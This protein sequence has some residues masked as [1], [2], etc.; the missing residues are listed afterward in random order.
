MA[1][2]LARLICCNRQR[3]GCKDVEI[4]LESKSA[5]MD[6]E[7]LVV[8]WHLLA[9][10]Y[11]VTAPLGLLSDYGHYGFNFLNTVFMKYCIAYHN[12]LCVYY[13]VLVVITFLLRSYN[14]S[15]V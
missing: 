13:N 10:L 1:S 9:G 4:I 6:T 5:Y 8:F 7:D 12:L 14:E 15:T 3:D 11:N 2:K